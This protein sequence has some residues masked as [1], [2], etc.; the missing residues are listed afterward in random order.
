MTSRSQA[1]AP[2]SA[3]RRPRRVVFVV[4]LLL[5]V[6]L[7]VELLGFVAFRLLTGGWFSPSTA[8]ALHAA[9]RGEVGDE[10]AAV[11]AAANPGTVVHPY[12]GFV[13]NREMGAVQG[14]PISP[15]GFVDAASPVRRRAADRYVV[16]LLGGSFALQLGLYAEQRLCDELARSPALAGRRVEVVRLALGG[17]KQPQ[18]LFAAELCWLLG[19][20]F[21]CVIDLDGFNEVALVDENLP[22]GVPGW[23]P[24]GWARLLDTVPTPAQQRRLGHLVVLREQRAALAAAADATS[25][26]PT[27]QCLWWWRDRALQGRI[28]TLAAEAERAAVTP[29]FAAT[30]P[31]ADPQGGV[32]ARRDNVALW[33]RASRQLDALCRVRG[34]RYFHFLQ[35]NQYVAGSKPIGAEEAAVAIDQTHPYAA[36]VREAWPLLREAGAALAAEGV[37]FTDLTGVLADHAEPLY[38][39]TCCHLG[40]AGYEIVA[41]AIAQAVR[42]RLDLDGFAVAGLEL[43]SAVPALADPARFVALPVVA[44]GAD[45]RRVDVAGR[46]FGTELVV[47]PAGALEVRADGAVRAC[48]RGPARVTATFRGAVATLELRADWGDELLLDD[49]A[50]VAPPALRVLGAGEG[51]RAELSCAGLAGSRLAVLAASL[52]PLPADLRPGDDAFGVVSALLPTATEAVAVSAPTAAPAGQPLFLRVYVVDPG[53]GEVVAASN[54]VVVTR[55]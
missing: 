23:F 13:T 36:A 54:S 5:L 51:G 30:G 41:A 1:T 22:Q 6:V 16:A 12:F 45:G 17:Y 19:G 34:A 8:T 14:F 29:S 21:D 42:A 3:R 18:Q 24:R 15:F 7:V 39:D 50:G 10:V 27:L 35:P 2:G 28:A 11:Q 20:E 31:G 52:R 55:G 32:A 38:V 47:E 46:G 37:A 49:G 48:R 53:S 25:W 44:I 40:R 9:A 4:A 33:Q 43:P 26:S